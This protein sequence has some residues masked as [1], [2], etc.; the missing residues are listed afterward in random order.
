MI[1]MSAAAGGNQ[2][3]IGG[4]GNL[5]VT[6]GGNIFGTGNINS[7]VGNNINGN[8]N[9]VLG[10]YNQ[11]QTDNAVVIGNNV[12]ATQ[13]GVFVLNQPLILGPQ[14]TLPVGTG[15]FITMS[16]GSGNTISGGTGSMTQGIGCVA[17]GTNSYAGGYNATSTNYSEWSRGN[18]S[19]FTSQYGSVLLSNFAN[20]LPFALGTTM[21]IFTDGTA[22]NFQLNGDY[23]FTAK[24][25]VNSAGPRDNV[26]FPDVYT[27]PNITFYFSNHNGGNIWSSAGVT[28]SRIDQNSDN[29]SWSRNWTFH[30]GLNIASAELNLSFSFDNPPGP[31]GPLGSG[32]WVGGCLL[33]YV[34][35][36]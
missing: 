29:T 31:A 17:S 1:D 33:E 16:V 28:V 11:I 35:L 14:G 7:G 2:K 9:Q 18:T 32:T 36:G 21:N 4:L 5:Q 10:H 20:V 15:D 27:F 24:P 12:T 30:I 25:F 19:L 8:Y 26:N 3:P 22:S 6:K 34:K 23:K 13:S